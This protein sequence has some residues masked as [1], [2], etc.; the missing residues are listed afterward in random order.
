M[1][2]EVGSGYYWDLTNYTINFSDTTPTKDDFDDVDYI[3]VE[4]GDD[5][6]YQLVDNEVVD[7]TNSFIITQSCIFPTPDETFDGKQ[8][9]YFG[10]NFELLTNHIYVIDDEDDFK[11]IEFGI[12]DHQHILYG[13][14]DDLSD[15]DILQYD[16]GID[17]FVPKTLNTP[18]SIL[19]TSDMS[20]L[21]VG[22]VALY[23][24]DTSEDFTKGHVY[25]GEGI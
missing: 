12:G 13:Y 14:S 4:D 22:D 17:A 21:G 1:D 16:Q 10:D 19:V 25:I 9:V 7:V 6:I 18:N 11:L 24:G 3:I 23:I 5:T 8:I 15:G 20:G 2:V